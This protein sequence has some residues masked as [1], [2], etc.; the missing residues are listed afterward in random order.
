MRRVRQGGQ[1][2]RL[3]SRCWWVEMTLSQLEQKYEKLSKALPCNAEDCA[4]CTEQDYCPVHLEV[5]AAWANWQSAKN[6][7]VAKKLL[8]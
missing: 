6:V 2:P 8:L 4:R 5:F 7:A 3:P 1:S